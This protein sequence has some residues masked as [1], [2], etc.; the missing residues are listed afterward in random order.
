LH[1]LVKFD[2][3]KGLKICGGAGA[4]AALGALLRRPFTVP[5]KN[6]RYKASV[7]ELP[8]QSGKIPFKFACLPLVHSDPVLGYRF[9]IDGRTIAF[10][11]DT[12]YCK[13]SVKLADKADLLISECSMRRG[14]GK[15]GWPHM[16]PRTASALAREAGAGKLGLVHFAASAYTK[17]SD[18]AEAA[19][20]AR[21]TF[22]NT[23]AACDEMRIKL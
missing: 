5:P 10:C 22:K 18:R 13:N 11:T 19:A 3:R 4:R 7:L 17:L 20:I 12:G 9:E 1:A 21:K 14:N 6:L 15:P 16:N 2:L 8:S 23:F